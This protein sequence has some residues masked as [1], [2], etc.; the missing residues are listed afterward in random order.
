MLDPK[1]ITSPNNKGIF[2]INRRNPTVIID[3]GFLSGLYDDKG[4]QLFEITTDDTDVMVGMAVF[5]DNGSVKDISKMLRINGEPLYLNTEYTEKTFISDC[6]FI[7]TFESVAYPK[8]TMYL[9]I[10]FEVL[11]PEPIRRKCEFVLVLSDSLSDKKD[12]YPNSGEI[13]SSVSSSALLLRTNP[14]LTGNIKLVVD[15][16]YRLYLDTFKVSQALSSNN[17]RHQNIASSGD[18]ARDVYTIFGGL[19][20]GE[21]YKVPDRTLDPHKKYTKYKSQY[22]TTYEY[23]AQTNDDNLYE[24][25]MRILAPLWIGN[26]LPDFFCIF[27]CP[28]YF[29][30]ETYDGGNYMNDTEV[31]RRILSEG[32]LVQSY[33]LRRSTTIGE[34]L[35]NYHERIKSNIGS[36]YLQ[37]N[38]QDAEKKYTTQGMNTWKGISVNRGVITDKYETTYFS[39][40]IFEDNNSTQEE[41]N[42]FITSGYERNNLVIPNIINLEFMFNDDGV[43]TYSMHRYYGLY[44]KANEFFRYAAVI[45]HTTMPST[46]LIKYDDNFD[47]IDDSEAVKLI[48]NKEYRDRIFLAVTDKSAGRVQNENDLS[49][50]IDEHVANVPHINV[51]ASPSEEIKTGISYV[52]LKFTHPISYGEHFRI[53][54]PDFELEDGTKTRAVFELVAS[55]DKRLL[56][57][58][59]VH[60]YVAINK[61]HLPQ[62]DTILKKYPYMMRMAFY[63]QAV[64]D[65]SQPA[66]IYEQLKRISHAITKFGADFYVGSMSSDAL[67]IIT[68]YSDSVFQHISDDILDLRDED[69]ETYRKADYIRYFDPTQITEMVPLDND[70]ASYTND[71]GQYAPID[72]E[73]LGWRMHTAVKFFKTLENSYSISGDAIGTKDIPTI[74]VALTTDGYKAL[75]HVTLDWVRPTPAGEEASQT[76][77]MRAMSPLNINDILIHLS[78]PA[79]LV[80]GGIQIYTPTSCTLN[81]MGV[82]SV[83]DMDTRLL[84]TNKET[85]TAEAAL[86]MDENER[87]CLDDVDPKI[88]RNR[89]YRIVEGAFYEVGIPEKSLFYIL[90][91]TVYYLTADDKGNPTTKYVS[92]PGNII[93]ATR[94]TKLIV[95]D[96]YPIDYN[97]STSYT[98]M[99]PVNFF[100]DP[101]NPSSTNLRYPISIPVV[102][103]WDSLGMYYD[104]NNVL[105]RVYVRDRN[106]QVEMRERNDGFFETYR[107]GTGKE[108]TQFVSDNLDE[109]IEIEGETVSFRNLIIKNCDIEVKNIIHQYLTSDVIPHHSVAYYNKYLDN[110]EF[111]YGGMKFILRL[112]SPMYNMDIRLNDYNNYK[113][114]VVSDYRPATNNEM[115][116]SNE[117]QT[118]L[119]VNHNFR[120]TDT[121]MEIGTY[122]NNVFGL[123]PGYMWVPNPWVI[124]PYRVFGT[125]KGVI[126]KKVRQT[127]AS[128]GDFEPLDW[129]VQ[130]SMARND[131]LSDWNY[132]VYFGTDPSG[133]EGGDEKSEYVSLK[134]WD[135]DKEVKL[136]EIHSLVN[137]VYNDGIEHGTMDG[138]QDN[139]VH[140]FNSERLALIDFQE[141]YISHA[142]RLRY[143][144]D[145]V[146]NKNLYDLYRDSL[147]A[148]MNI[149][150]MSPG[151]ETK[152]INMT[153]SYKPLSIDILEPN[154]IKYNNGYY[155]PK[156]YDV[157]K[158]ATREDDRISNICKNNFLLGNTRFES[159]SPILNYVCNKVFDQNYGTGVI[160]SNFFIIPERSILSTNWDSNFY[161]LYTGQDT[162]RLEDGY[163]TGVEEKTFF[164]S[165][166]MC[167]NGAD[168]EITDWSDDATNT[169]IITTED[170]LSE[171]GVNTVTR[172]THIVRINL[173]KA[174]YK[175]FNEKLKGL[176]SPFQ[177][178]ENT[179]IN[180]FITQSFLKYFRVNDRNT[181]HLYMENDS[182]KFG[183]CPQMPEDFE[184]GWSEIKNFGCEYEEDNNEITLVVTIDRDRNLY[185]ILRL[186][187]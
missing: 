4:Q 125:D 137:T 103:Y 24:E 10:E 101:N 86:Y 80:N 141:S 50:F 49:E 88:V 12:I 122:M 79:V 92:L 172:K 178:Y 126:Y 30:Q 117:E 15:T 167:L 162:Y 31:F 173:T 27:R 171:Q 163:R 57:T 26:T 116:V 121:E 110:L 35:N 142:W 94:K 123:D 166:C 139:Q 41:L 33:D 21:L 177:S 51:I 119:I 144:K 152:V 176:M 127:T 154:Y 8:D 109:A 39:N 131:V 23:G 155:I 98:E 146:E 184:T 108:T 157:V 147:T 165:T 25:N 44:L 66:T 47:E 133:M 95:E 17:Y 114:Y 164:G 180:N 105:D 145:P 76:T 97:I 74:A 168:V 135:T 151:S 52:A 99:L 2:F 67:S 136:F 124:D 118:I 96:N 63:T 16:N 53:L 56:D 160:D 159:V 149:Y 1:L 107:P 140:R 175:V 130:T 18:Y 40:L 13:L 73:I 134:Y 158:F 129:Y 156:M 54:V 186:K 64:D 102:H 182:D 106:Y 37:F 29:N 81:L 104:H 161:R 7:Y 48:N 85:Y 6:H 138:T 69:K 83:R 148:D 28:E 181:F 36:C 143:S 65:P 9:R 132:Y 45:R 68:S 183:I 112:S 128:A 84:Y 5:D 70:T 77:V 78:D 22:E 62:A 150:I 120:T 93:T 91:N 185:P 60:P 174:V 43:E 169:A 32:V 170:K 58:D 179:H 59:F 111:I 82:L 46:E 38:E 113:I 72:F 115:F 87:V 61:N 153:K 42:H 100:E 3:A 90:E 71:T 75:E 187:R 34:Y 55:N 89:R 20:R 19:G 14:K 11:Q